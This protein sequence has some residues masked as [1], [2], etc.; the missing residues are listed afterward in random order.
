MQ[1]CN[2]CLFPT[3]DNF[4]GAY[5]AAQRSGYIGGLPAQGLGQPSMLF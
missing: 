4:L 5:G 2:I 3:V 1:I